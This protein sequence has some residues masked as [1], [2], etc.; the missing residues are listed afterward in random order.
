MRWTDDTHA[1][2]RVYAKVLGA[3]ARRL[4]NLSMAEDVLQDALV[5]ALEKWRYSA[6][7]AD[8]AAWLYKVAWRKALDRLAREHTAQEAMPEILVA[9]PASEN[10]PRLTDADF[11]DDELAM[12]FLCAHPALSEEVQVTLMLRTVC[13]LSV[14]QIAT[15]LLL[16]QA[17]V[18]Q[19]IVRAKRTLSAIP[20]P[21]DVAAMSDVED[22][23][24]AVRHAIYLMFTEGYAASDGDALV[25]R[26]LCLEAIRL[27]ELLA[28]SRV[29]GTAETHAL[30]ALLHFQ[31]SRTAA[32][33]RDGVAVPLGDQDR[34][35]WDRLSISRGFQWLERSMMGAE[36]SRYHLQAGIASVHALAPDMASTNWVAIDD[37]YRQLR[38][39]GDSAVL[40]LNHAVALSYTSGVTQALELLDTIDNSPLARSHLLFATRAVLYERIGERELAARN[41]REALLVAR[42]LPEHRLLAARLML[43][44]PEQSSGQ[45]EILPRM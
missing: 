44:A 39:M 41:A 37:Y 27:S 19:R 7:P 11:S 24:S 40:R 28:S 43:L 6:A 33:E 10:A 1:L 18:S 30:C 35:L 20:T 3:L 14:A 42:T 32:R 21:F 25:R 5:S 38:A 45:E 36:L 26:E 16:P 31:W 15:A 34:T 22:R 4:G 2:R 17:T 23:V 29:G 13:S 12:L 9:M 8:P